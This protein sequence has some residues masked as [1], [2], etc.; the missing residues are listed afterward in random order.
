MG[1]TA[2][3]YYAYDMYN[4]YVKVVL[5]LFI[6]FFFAATYD[7]YQTCEL[8]FCSADSLPCIERKEKDFFFPLP[9]GGP[10]SQ[11]ASLSAL[12]LRMQAPSWILALSC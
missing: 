2:V 12:P 7:M 6:V 11:G 4:T 10:C 8:L 5:A 3:S 1:Q 9:M